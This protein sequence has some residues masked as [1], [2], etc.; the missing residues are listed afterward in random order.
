MMSTRHF[1]SSVASKPHLDSLAVSSLAVDM[2]SRKWGERHGWY[3]QYARSDAKQRDSEFLYPVR[4]ARF[5][6]VEKETQ[7]MFLIIG[8]ES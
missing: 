1:S 7:S 5:H 4:N 6:G 3:L 8:I 2:R